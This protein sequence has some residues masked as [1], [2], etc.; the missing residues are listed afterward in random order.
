MRHLYTKHYVNG[1]K[2]PEG[3]ELTLH[4]CTLC[5]YESNEERKVTRHMKLQARLGDALPAEYVAISVEGN[6]TTS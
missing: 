2:I 5:D 6:D 3:Y 1:E 4:K